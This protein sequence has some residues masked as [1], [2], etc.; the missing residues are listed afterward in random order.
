M[1]IGCLRASDEEVSSSLMLDQQGCHG[2]PTKARLHGDGATASYEMGHSVTP[3]PSNSIPG[4]KQREVNGIHRD[5]RT[6]MLSATPFI[7][8]KDQAQSCCST[9]AEHRPATEAI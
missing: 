7:I 6:R 4:S 1:D 8:V 5:T 9:S 2:E 3:N